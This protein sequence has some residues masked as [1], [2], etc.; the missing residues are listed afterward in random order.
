MIKK[1]AIL[2]H[3]YYA[4]TLLVIGI[5][6][7]YFLID[8]DLGARFKNFN[9]ELLASDITFICALT[10]GIVGFIFLAIRKNKKSKIKNS[11]IITNAILII[12]L[13]LMLALTPFLETIQPG[14]VGD[15]KLSFI[16]GI[17]TVIGMFAFF[18][19]I[20]LLILTI[21]RQLFIILTSKKEK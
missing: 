3:F 13:T 1:I 12:P 17:I 6:T 2:I 16:V 21:I 18:V 8:T 19:W 20:V 5:I 14:E 4:M 10:V 11:T 7:K 15:S 9:H